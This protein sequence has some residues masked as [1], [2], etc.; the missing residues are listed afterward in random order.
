MKSR[1]GF[2]AAKCPICQVPILAQNRHKF[3]LLDSIQLGS[4]RP[5]LNRVS[6]GVL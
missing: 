6:L 5:Y 3:K 2:M 4:K 1:I